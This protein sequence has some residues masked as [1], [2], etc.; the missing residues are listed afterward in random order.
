MCK[1][2]AYYD[3]WSTYLDMVEVS[4]SSLLMPTK[5]ESPNLIDWDFFCACYIKDAEDNLNLSYIIILVVRLAYIEL[6]KR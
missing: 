4:S 5:F 1:I 6:K 3:I 2:R